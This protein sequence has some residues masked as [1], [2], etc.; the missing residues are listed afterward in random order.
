LFFTPQRYHRGRGVS[1]F[2]CGAS[3]ARTFGEEVMKSLLSILAATLLVGCGA[4]RP[5]A[6]QS[7]KND[8]VSRDGMVESVEGISILFPESEKL[9]WTAVTN[10][11]QIDQRLIALAEG[12]H[13]VQGN[14]TLSVQRYAT[15]GNYVLLCAG[16]DPPCPDCSFNWV[17]RRSDMKY[18]GHFLDRNSR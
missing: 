2:G 14:R 18:I 8:Y 5:V 11:S 9:E 7:T 15:I 3:R 4:D 12:R 13:P 10:S 17:V 16:F 6:V 1:N